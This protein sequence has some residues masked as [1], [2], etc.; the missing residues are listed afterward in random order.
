M[1][2]CVFQPIVATPP[3]EIET[4]SEACYEA[5]CRQP[6][7]SACLVC[8]DHAGNACGEQ[9]RRP[10]T[11][12]AKLNGVV[13]RMLTAGTAANGQTMPE[14]QVN[15]LRQLSITPSRHLH[16]AHPP[17]QDDCWRYDGCG[18]FAG[19]CEMPGMW[20]THKLPVR[21]ER[22]AKCMAPQ[23]QR[24]NSTMFRLATHNHSRSLSDIWPMVCT[25]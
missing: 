15:N 7:R 13:K 25:L 3:G 14:L 17:Q 12:T 4:S 20:P 19:T 21:N 1:M 23:R 10:T 22:S 6:S 18:K 2:T 24:N 8:V 9:G 16:D 11:T 5:V